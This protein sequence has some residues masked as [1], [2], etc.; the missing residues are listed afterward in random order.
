MYRR[1]RGEDYCFSSEIG[2]VLVRL[3][4]QSGGCNRANQTYLGAAPASSTLV[5]SRAGEGDVRLK[6][7]QFTRDATIHTRRDIHARRD[8]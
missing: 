2:F 5:P 3:T 4:N 7:G 8:I 1:S 6:V